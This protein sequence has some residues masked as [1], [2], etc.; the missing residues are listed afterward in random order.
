MRIRT[1]ERNSSIM[2]D[3]KN[4]IEWLIQLRVMNPES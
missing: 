2:N 1:L 3:L 4:N